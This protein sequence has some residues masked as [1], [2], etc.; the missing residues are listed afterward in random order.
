MDTT[1]QMDVFIGTLVI[2][3]ATA[4]NIAAIMAAIIILER[5]KDVYLI[6]DNYMIK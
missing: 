1:V 6:K 5:D 4:V 2:E 3:T